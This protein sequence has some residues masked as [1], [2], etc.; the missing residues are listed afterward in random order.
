MPTSV[1]SVKSL[2]KDEF[3]GLL[4][5]SS[6]P[7][8]VRS[9]LANIRWPFTSVKP[10][11]VQLEAL[12]ASEGKFGFAFFM[13]QRLGKT[14]TAYAEFMNLREDDRVDWMFIICP[15]SLKRQW[16]DAIEEVN[17][18]ESILVY[19]SQSKRRADRFFKRN[20]KGGVIIINYESMKSFL[21]D[22]YGVC[23]DTLRTYC[24][25]DEST[26]I[27][28]PGNST[29]KACLEFSALCTYTRVLA[30]KPTAN[31]HAD[32]WSQLKFIRATERNYHQHKYTFCICG[33]Y[34][35]RQAVSN[36]NTEMLQKE[37]APHVYIAPD[38]YVKGFQKVYEPLRRVQL[39]P[40]Q[41]KQ[42]K[43]MEDDLVLELGNDTNITAPIALVR[44]LRL[45][46]ISSCVAGDVSG[47]QHNLVDP[48]KNPR[49]NVVR[50]LLDNEI[51]G[52]CIIVCR[53]R[54][55]VDNL[56]RVL[57]SDGYNVVTLVGGM[58]AAEIEEAKASFNGYGSEILIAQMQVLSFGH[59]L[60]GHE[61]KPCRDMI[62]YENDFSILNRM[63]CESRPEVYGRDE[64][65]SHWDMYS[66][67]MDRYIMQSLRKKED[68]SLA[69]MNYARSTGFRPTSEDE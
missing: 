66:S 57:T 11:E 38:K 43:Q 63:Q 68:G 13:R 24:V 22:G 52:K 28:D 36:I 34:M 35:G 10:R 14:L 48:F 17:I 5:K 6:A 21:K 49:I 12:Q 29:S 15:N 39:L 1:P 65:I 62:H 27:K 2:P 20:K 23:F 47:V 51:D 4:N 50:G 26:K 44:Y 16:R 42:Y 40:E 61:N 53:F 58:S 67:K 46:Q 60:P 7:T 18:Y 59:T 25:A 9:D 33:G 31:S 56:V 69:L 45:Q 8:A 37:M 55:S 64:P 32:I 30:G 3:F 41:L 19:D 54:L